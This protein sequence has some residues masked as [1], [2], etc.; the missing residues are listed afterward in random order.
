[1]HPHQY[2]ISRDDAPLSGV[3]V[4]VYPHIFGYKLT[5]KRITGAQDATSNAKSQRINLQNKGLAQNALIFEG[6]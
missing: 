6:K 5:D 4:N 1:M 3:L 2:L